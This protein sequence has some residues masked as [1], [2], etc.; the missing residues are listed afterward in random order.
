M[1]AIERLAGQKHEQQD[2][3]EHTC[4]HFRHGQR[5]LRRISAKFGERDNQPGDD[6]G[7]RVQTRQKG[8]DNGGKAVAE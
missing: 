5:D 6:H 7:K 8:H 4:H 2:A 3:L 1:V